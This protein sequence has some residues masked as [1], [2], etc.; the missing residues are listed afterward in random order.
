MSIIESRVGLRMWLL[1]FA[2]AMSIAGCASRGDNGTNGGRAIL[3]DESFVLVPICDA[4]RA[5]QVPVIGT[6]DAIT[7]AVAADLRSR[8]FGV[9]IASAPT[10]T[11]I[12]EAA[13]GGANLILCGNFLEWQPDLSLSLVASDLADNEVSRSY[14]IVQGGVR[15]DRNISINELAA[16][17]ISGLFKQRTRFAGE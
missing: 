15:N 1:V 8:G 12:E 17:G 5:R 6:G 3:A 14:A 16:R 2:L 10:A 11:A 7:L 13:K 4:K 9:T